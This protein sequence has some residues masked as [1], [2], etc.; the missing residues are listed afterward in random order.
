MVKTLARQASDM[1]YKGQHT[2]EQHAEAHCFSGDL[3]AVAPKRDGQELTLRQLVQC[4]EFCLGLI[5]LVG[6]HPPAD[7]THTC[8][9]LLHIAV[10]C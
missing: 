8:D 3:D 2:V 1:G 7:I 4:T 10:Y 9:Q 5:K 6:T